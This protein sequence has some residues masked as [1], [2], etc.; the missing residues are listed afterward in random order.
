MSELQAETAFNDVDAGTILADGSELAPDSAEE[1]EEKDPA[2]LAQD[3]AQKAINRQHAKYREEERK[4]IEI[5]KRAKELEDKLKE[6]ESKS[7]DVVVPPLPDPWDEDYNQ[8][9]AA[10]DEALRKQAI[11][12]AQKQYQDS[13]AKTSQEAAAK[14]EQERLQGLV[15]DYDKNTIKLGL[16]SAEVRKAG[17]VVVSYGISDDL[18]GFILQDSEGPL[19]TKYL[20]ANP[21]V[22]DELRNLSPIQA[23]LQINSDIRAAA[24]KLK[25]QATAAP[26]P[27]DILGGRGAGEKQSALIKGATFE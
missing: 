20:A 7:A 2:A 25:P 12:D 17:E 4:R 23:A 24:S 3:Q 14:A 18:I 9:I 10:R 22:L 15:K 26:D 1:R 8:K 19:I 5:E 6:L 13:Q 27:A 21:L 16:D 11:I